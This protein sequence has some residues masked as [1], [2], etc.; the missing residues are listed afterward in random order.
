MKHYKAIFEGYIETT[1]ES[2]PDDRWDRDDTAFVLTGIRVEPSDEE[3]SN[4][5]FGY[6]RV[7]DFSA[8]D[9]ATKVYLVYAE[10][11]TGDTFGREEGQV[12]AFDTFE[13]DYQANKLASRLRTAEGYSLGND[14]GEDYYIPWNGYF[15]SLTDVSVTELSLF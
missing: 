2:D 13:F 1:R 5:V 7:F 11:S 3:Q 10:Y 12:I 15:E 8:A 6:D 4:N 9:D 14:H